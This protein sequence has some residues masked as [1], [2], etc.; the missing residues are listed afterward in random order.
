MSATKRKNS[1]ES[2]DHREQVEDINKA[3][4]E[5][6]IPTS[7]PSSDGLRRRNVKNTNSS[8]EQEPRTSNRPVRN[9]GNNITSLLVLWALIFV[10]VM[11]ALRRL[12]YMWNNW[13]TST[14]GDPKMYLCNLLFLFEWH[15]IRS[16]LNHCLSCDSFIHVLLCVKHYKL[17]LVSF[18]ICSV[19]MPTAGCVF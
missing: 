15:F 2:E 1:T 8:T 12:L 7:S 19:A 4:T 18:V 17:C 9:E 11:L 5:T 13:L 6:V 14:A 10:I 16:A 3:Q